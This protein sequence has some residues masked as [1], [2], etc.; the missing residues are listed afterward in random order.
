MPGT[1]TNA[2]GLPSRPG[3]AT[4]DKSRSPWLAAEH[5]GLGD[6]GLN[7][8]APHPHEVGDPLRMRR[9]LEVGEYQHATQAVA[10]PVDAVASGLALDVVEN[11][12]HVVVDQ[13]VDR[14]ARLASFAQERPAQGL[15]DPVAP[16]DL[17][18]LTRA[19][20]VEHVDL[21]SAAANCAG[22]WLSVIVQKVALSPRP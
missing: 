20:D 18:V 4:S 6:L 7:D 14:P 17:G 10:D 19:P 3:L 2:S 1:R 22:R 11:G 13:V 15:V 8:R 12:R 21:V 16:P 9:Q 5:V